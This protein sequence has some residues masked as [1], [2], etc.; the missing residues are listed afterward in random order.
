MVS[1]GLLV[2][3]R[4]AGCP[5]AGAVTAQT[6]TDRFHAAPPPTDHRAKP[7]GMRDDTIVPLTT[8]CSH[9]TY[10]RH[11]LCRRR[12]CL[13][14]SPRGVYL[15]PVDQRHLIIAITGGS[16]SGKTD[17]IRR[18]RAVFGTEEVCIISHDDYTFPRDR[19]AQDARGIPNFDR[20][21]AI[22]QASFRRDVATLLQGE[23]VTRQEY[24]FNNPL[25]KPRTLTF[26]PAPVLVVE[27]LFVLH[28]PEMRG[29]AN[30]RIFLE[31]KESLRL[32]RRICRDQRERRYPLE[33]VLYRYEHHVLPCYESHIRPYREACD[34]I[35]NNNRSLE[36]GL[37]VLC[38][39]VREW[40]RNRPDAA[41]AD[42]A[43]PGSP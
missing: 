41:P 16:G 30:L 10:S 23:S 19:Q 31:A 20:P 35:I 15:A 33:D 11:R 1:T 38:A 34:L 39:F 18:L 7:G 42:T 24:N 36:T 29:L 3:S 13:G 32:I 6:R 21:D 40:L 8:P 17:F 12:L 43:M 2:N 9:H 22:D 4:R 5:A 27:G 28:C 25:A 37:Q 14:S 26:L